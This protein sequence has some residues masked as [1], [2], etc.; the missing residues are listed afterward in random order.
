MAPQDRGQLVHAA[1]LRRLADHTHAIASH[2]AE[3]VAEVAAVLCTDA[4]ES[5]ARD[6]PDA[7]VSSAAHVIAALQSF[8]PAGSPDPGSAAASLVHLAEVRKRIATAEAIAL[9]ITTKPDL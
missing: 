6:L 5:V 1:L 9:V 7:L 2:E 3:G 8:G 4:L